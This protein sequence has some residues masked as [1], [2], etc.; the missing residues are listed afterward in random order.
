MNLFPVSKEMAGCK[1]EVSLIVEAYWFRI[2]QENE[3][4]GK[5]K[6]ADPSIHKCSA[7]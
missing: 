6:L 5:M 4:I 2:S 7:I 3:S 1:F